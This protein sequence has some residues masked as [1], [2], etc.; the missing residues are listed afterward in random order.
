MRAFVEKSNA[1]TIGARTV[2]LV[3]DLQRG[4]M[5]ECFDA[6]HVLTRAADLVA[7]ARENG[8]AIVWVQD[9][10]VA[11]GTSDGELAAPLS[12]NDDESLVRKTYR[13]A[14][15]GTNLKSVLD[16]LGATRLVVAGAQSDYCIRTTVQRAA[17]EGY[18][19]TLVSDAHTTTSAEWDGVTITGEQIVAHTNRYFSGLRYPGQICDIATHDAVRL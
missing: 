6:S 9:D 8:T 19:I 10:G 3:I 18:D 7:R 4:V 12:R 1:M 17:A 5:A 16:G 2:V 11:L 15:A 13:D 14:F